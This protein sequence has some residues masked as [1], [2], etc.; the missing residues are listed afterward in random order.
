MG[1]WASRGVHGAMAMNVCGA[2]SS[3]YAYIA[4]KWRFVAYLATKCAENLATVGE[5]MIKPM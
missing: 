2:H 4:T 3:E 5:A 1:P